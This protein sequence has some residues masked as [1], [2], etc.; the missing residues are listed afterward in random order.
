VS[1]ELQAWITALPDG[2]N[3]DFGKSCYLVNQTI[4]ITGKH[5]IT[6]EG[7]KFKATTTGVE[8]PPWDNKPANWPRQRAHLIINGGSTNI[9]VNR[10]QIQ[11]INV[12]YEFNTGLEGQAGFVVSGGSDHVTLNNVK[13][14]DVYGDFVTVSGDSTFVTVNQLGGSG[15]GRQGVALTDTSDAVVQNSS[16]FRVR[17]SC[18][19]IEPLFNNS[20]A[21][22]HRAFILQNVFVECGN[23]TVGVGGSGLTEDVTISANDSTQPWYSK[24]GGGLDSGY[25]IF[26]DNESHGAPTT[27]LMVDMNG[28][29]SYTISGNVMPIAPQQCNKGVCQGGY[30]LSVD[31]VL[32]NP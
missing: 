15:A 26:T 25:M 32:S 17:R 10:L 28:W 5:N 29:E 6:F 1:T 16:F 19:D 30:W 31:G 9:T 23:T 3:V 11:S 14:T 7:G 22:V 12:N 18:I 27:R 2:S 20:E 24:L 8:F 21:E 13:V 4:L